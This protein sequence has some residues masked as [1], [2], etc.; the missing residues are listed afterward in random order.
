LLLRGFILDDGD[1]RC[2][3]ASLDYCGLMNSAHDELCAALAAAAGTMAERVSVHCIHQ[4]DAPL[5]DFEIEAY[6]G[7]AGDRLPGRMR[8]QLA[9]LK[10]RVGL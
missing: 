1:Q 5:L 6:L 8:A 10:G 4:H 3:L 2:L 7:R 9:E